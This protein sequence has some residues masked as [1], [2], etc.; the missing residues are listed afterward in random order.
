MIFLSLVLKPKIN[1]LTNIIIPVL[2]FVTMLGAC[3]G[4]TWN[5]YIFGTIVES[6]LLFLIIRYAIKWPKNDQ[7]IYNKVNL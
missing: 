3:I 2:Y 6:M 1:R 7:R 4:E 5:F